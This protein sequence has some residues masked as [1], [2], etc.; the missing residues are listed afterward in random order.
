MESPVPPPT[1]LP[2]GIPPN[3]YNP[4]CWITGEPSIGPGTWIGAF[5]LIDGQGGLSIGRG[6]DISCGA[7]ILTHSTVKR[8]LT[9]RKHAIVDRHPTTIEDHVFVGTNAVILMGSHVGHHCVIAA[10]AVV[11]EHS[12]I[13]PYSLV[14]GVP[15]RVVRNIEAE[16][17]EWAAGETPR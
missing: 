6:C 10:G 16:V 15:G 7:Q 5:T 12:R 3:P 9:E 8:C 13:P 1:P 17:A 11:L 2:H 4:H 14:A